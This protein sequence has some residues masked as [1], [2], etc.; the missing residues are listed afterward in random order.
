[1]RDIMAYSA[2]AY[3]VLYDVF[4]CARIYDNKFK[5][6]FH[7]NTMIL[8]TLPKYMYMHLYSIQ[9]NILFQTQM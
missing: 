9:F 6:T 4:L 1:M 7:G 2:L 8:S 5:I 3:N